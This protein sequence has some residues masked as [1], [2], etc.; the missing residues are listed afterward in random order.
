L[1]HELVLGLGLL[2]KIFMDPGVVIT[3]LYRYRILDF[4]FESGVAYN[5][6]AVIKIAFLLM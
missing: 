5:L 1:A 2:V 4:L 3:E 6:L